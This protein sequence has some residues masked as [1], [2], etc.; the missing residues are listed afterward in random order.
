MNGVQDAFGRLV[1]D[2]EPWLD[3]VV[4]VGGWAHQLYRLHPNAQELSYPPLTTLDTAGT[5]GSDGAICRSYAAAEAKAGEVKAVRLDFCVADSCQITP[6]QRTFPR[7][8]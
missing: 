7:R 4:V 3:Q 1:A 8:L 2:L 5:K 6:A